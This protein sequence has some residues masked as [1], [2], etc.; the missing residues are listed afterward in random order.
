MVNSDTYY[1]ESQLL[2]SI[3]R[4]Q[5]AK[6]KGKTI[7]IVKIYGHD[8]MLNLFVNF[9]W[10]NWPLLVHWQRWP[11]T[12]PAKRS[13]SWR[14]SRASRSCAGPSWPR[15]T[16]RTRRWA[17]KRPTSREAP[18]DANKN[19][20]SKRNFRMF[21]WGR[22]WSCLCGNWNEVEVEL[23]ISCLREFWMTCLLEFGIC[24]IR[25]WSDWTVDLNDHPTIFPGVDLVP[26]TH[27]LMFHD[28]SMLCFVPWMFTNM[29]NPIRGFFLL[30]SPFVLLQTASD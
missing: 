1:F 23:D 30:H 22:F 11:L 18:W 2:I 5:S 12:S 20:K 25:W 29:F 14:R 8:H 9:Y 13:V 17:K 16:W 28:V 24:K 7:K 6:Q 26:L 27:G 4:Y 10:S 21:F 19:G 3:C 15:R